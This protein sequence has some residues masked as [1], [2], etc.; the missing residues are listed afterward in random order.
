MI[1][2]SCNT[3][4]KSRVMAAGW[5]S[6]EN[7]AGVG[8]QIGRAQA[9]LEPAGSFELLGELTV[10]GIAREG[11]CLRGLRA[12]SSNEEHGAIGVSRRELKVRSEVCRS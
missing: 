1:V 3:A 7:V 12:G 8:E 9:R 2:S 5:C 6:G 11:L 10:W 4:S